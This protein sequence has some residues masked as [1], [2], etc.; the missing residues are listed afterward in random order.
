MHETH[1]SDSVTIIVTLL[2]FVCVVAI[3]SFLEEIRCGNV[4]DL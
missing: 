3:P 4:F 1:D 2:L